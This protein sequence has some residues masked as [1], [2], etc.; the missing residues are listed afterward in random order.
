M[1]VFYEVSGVLDTRKLCTPSQLRQILDK[2]SRD[3]VQVQLKGNQFCI[4]G[5]LNQV[6]QFEKKVRQASQAI[7]VFGDIDDDA[8]K[9]LKEILGGKRKQEPATVETQRSLQNKHYKLIPFLLALAKN[10][11]KISKKAKAVSIYR[12]EATDEEKHS[13]IRIGFQGAKIETDQLITYIQ[14]FYEKED[15]SQPYLLKKV[16]GSPTLKDFVRDKCLAKFKPTLL[17]QEKDDIY[18]VVSQ[19][20]CEKCEKWIEKVISS[21]MFEDY[22]QKE[23]QKVLLEYT[24]DG[25]LKEQNHGVDEDPEDNHHTA[26]HGLQED[27]DVT[28]NERETSKEKDDLKASVRN[29]KIIEA[30]ESMERQNHAEDTSFE[31]DHNNSTRGFDENTAVTQQGTTKLF[32]EEEYVSKQTR[33]P[34]SSVANRTKPTQSKIDESSKKQY[35]GGDQSSEDEDY[36]DE[37][38]GLTKKA[39]AKELCKEGVKKKV[40]STE[41]SKRNRRNSSDSEPDKNSNQKNYTSDQD[42]HSAGSDPLRDNSEED[43]D[44]GQHDDEVHDQPVKFV[45]DPNSVLYIETFCKETVKQLEGKHHVKLDFSRQSEGTILLKKQKQEPIS[46]MI[47]DAIGEQMQEIYDDLI[48]REIGTRSNVLEHIEDISNICRSKKVVFDTFSAENKIQLM[49]QKGVIQE[50]ALKI[51]ELVGKQSRKLVRSFS[52]KSPS[53]PTD[54]SPIVQNLNAT[55]DPRSHHAMPQAMAYQHKKTKVVI[56]TQLGDITKVTVDAIVNAANREL[57][58]FGGKILLIIRL[59]I[60]EMV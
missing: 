47:R 28:K 40:H 10:H 56:H 26:I 41:S 22:Y 2:L 31:G 15:D 23:I 19:T 50:V 49:G 42:E 14:G 60:T 53:S 43:M 6:I 34:G 37:T 54:H 29:R 18:V 8:L 24:V 25:R 59:I 35:H 44:Y 57:R 13:T 11:R 17:V 4:T 9:F 39:K 30:G 36:F 55:I 38:T 51:S 5:S 3:G 1:P 58:H 52:E 16:A 46:E 45:L 48:T 20:Q 12:K 33:R 32:K 21:E 7:Q 27:T